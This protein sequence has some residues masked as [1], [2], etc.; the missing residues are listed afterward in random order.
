MHS[1]ILN[2]PLPSSN[3][4]LIRPVTN[5]ILH[6]LYEVEYELEIRGTKEKMNLLLPNSTRS[7]KCS[8][9]NSSFS[10]LLLPA[11]ATA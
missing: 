10:F 2:K 1:V 11:A 4:N 5:N 9:F 8:A 7:F 6:A 3:I